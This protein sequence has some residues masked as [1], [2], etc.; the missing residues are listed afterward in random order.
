MITLFSL[1]KPFRGHVAMTQRNAI[2]SWTLLRPPCEILVFGNDEGVA[3]IAAEFNLQHIPDVAYNEY[4]TPLLN[5]VFEQAQLLATYQ[6]LCYVNAD[7][8]LMDDFM[9]AVQ[10]VTARYTATPFLMVGQR[11]DIDIQRDDLSFTSTWE[12]KLRRH[13]KQH[14]RLHDVDGIDYFVFAKG[15][16]GEIPPFVVGRAGWD[17]WM[18]YRARQLGI[19]VID[20]TP[21]VIVVHQNHDYSHVKGGKS[22]AYEGA[23][24]IQNRQLGGIETIFNIRDATYTLSSTAVEQACDKESL[25]QRLNRQTLLNRFSG[26]SKLRRFLLIWII[27][28]WKFYLLCMP[29]IGRKLVYNWLEWSEKKGKDCSR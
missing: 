25:W 5:D 2:R 12:G 9:L 11:W 26:N 22:T 16:W 21:E 4:G 10:H 29:E 19:A 24:A 20:A 14:G 28:A 7:I 23:E 13:I 27:R 18:I 8:I 6:T 1:P 15:M 3:S 17:N